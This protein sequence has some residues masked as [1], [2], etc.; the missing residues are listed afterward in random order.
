MAARRK[1][2]AKKAPKKS[3]GKAPKAKK[4]KKVKE[5]KVIKPGPPLESVLLLVTGLLLIGALFTLDFVKGRDYEE[6]M[7]FKGE[8]QAAE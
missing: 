7:L 2:A 8:Y 1:K 3:K 6:G 5:P 4:E